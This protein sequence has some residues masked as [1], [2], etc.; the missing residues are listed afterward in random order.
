VDIAGEFSSP[1]PAKNLFCL[2]APKR[3]DHGCI[4]NNLF[5]NVKDVGAR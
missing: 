4:I 3:P 2:A 5:I 1:F